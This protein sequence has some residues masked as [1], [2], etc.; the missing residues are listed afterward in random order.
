MDPKLKAGYSNRHVTYVM[1]NRSIKLL[2]VQVLLL[3]Q[4]INTSHEKFVENKS[5]ANS[6]K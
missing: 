1:K 4:K 5:Q 2:S 6:K 3:N